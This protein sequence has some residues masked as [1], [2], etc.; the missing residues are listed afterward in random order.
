MVAGAGAIVA[1]SA[2]SGRA[3][4]L[5]DVKRWVGK[6][7]ASPL[8]ERLTAPGEAALDAVSHAL[9]RLTFGARP[10][11]HA[12]VT[13]MGVAAFIEEQLAPAKIDDWVCERVIRHEL[14]SLAE[15]E[16]T[17]FPRKGDA[18]DPLQQI[19]PAMKDKGARVGDLYEFKD[20]VLLEELTRGTLLRAVL[21]ERQLFEVMVQFWSDH[22]NIDPS[23]AEAKWLKTADDRDVIRAH[24]LGNFRE[25]LRASAVSPAMLWYLDGRVNRKSQP[26]EKPN[27][28]YAR[29]L[30]ELHTLG[31]HGGY[32]QQDVMEVARCLT[33]WTVRD[34]K[35]FF[36]GRVEFQARQ[37]DDGAKR[38]L[39]VDIPAGQGA[40]DLDRVLEIV[41]AH[42]STAKHVAWKLCRRFIADEPPPAAVEATAAAFAKS[43]GDVAATLRVLFATEEFLQPETRGGKFKRPF[44]FVV[45]ALRATNAETDA[46]KPLVDFLLRL[47]HAPF[48]YTTPD[49]YPETATHWQNTLLWRWNFA[50]ALAENRI[51]GTRVAL[52]E[53]T[54]K[55][56]GDDAMMATL[57]G[58]RPN[59]VE[60]EAFH[61]SGAGVALLV[62]SPAFQHC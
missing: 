58:R 39:G 36:K 50:A 17:L 25:M 40:R 44:H 7:T 53:L 19:F 62:A 41:V 33:G 56:G 21:S 42:P 31:V 20:K 46:G 8:A 24:A 11:D 30:L 6:P 38:V 45:S 26:E 49:G 59:A 34:R 18:N 22:F 52:E 2:G 43:G 37:H 13:A 4:V 3:D 27:E 47:G 10:G 28:N 9:N 48:R 51:K 55:V 54:T 23:K 29:E 14:A 60:R 15:P 1:A 5:N 32:T 35:K 16:S 12:R 57:L 61:Q